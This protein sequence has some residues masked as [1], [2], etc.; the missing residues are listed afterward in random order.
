MHAGRATVVARAVGNQI[1]GCI[2]QDLDAVEHAGCEAHAAGLTVVEEDRRVS[3]LRV[4]GV[5]DTRN[6]VSIAERKQRE[7]RECGV[8]RRV[9]ATHDVAPRGF[10]SLRD[11]VWKL[12]PDPNRFEGRG[13]QVEGFGAEQILPSDATPLESGDG[14]GDLDP[15]L[16]DPKGASRG[17]IALA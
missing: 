11:F 9:D 5:G 2:E 15:A 17:G 6:V 13:R 3:D 8:F 10:E 7:E 4:T 1:A 16:D 12:E 14:L